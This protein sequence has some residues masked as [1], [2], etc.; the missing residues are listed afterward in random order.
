MNENKIFPEVGNDVNNEVTS[1]PSITPVEETVEVPTETVV[2]TP[3]VEVESSTEVVETPVVEPTLDFPVV[4]EVP[5]TPE[6]VETP[7]V[8][9]P[10]METPAVEETPIVEVEIPTLEVPAVETVEVPTEVVEETPVEVETPAVEPALDFPTVEEVPATPEVVEAPMETVEMTTPVEETPVVEQVMPVAENPEV[11]VPAENTTSAMPNGDTPKKNTLLPIIIV[12]IA[13]ALI[14][15]GAWFLF[16]RGAKAEKLS[17]QAFDK[18][19]GNVVEMTE[20]FDEMKIYEKVTEN[21]EVTV[22]FSSAYLASEDYE[23][24]EAV[25]EFL[26]S[27]L[28]KYSGAADVNTNN[29]HLDTILEF[30]KEEI[31]DLGFV[32]QDGKYYFHVLNKYVDVTDEIM[33]EMDGDTEQV[34]A[35]LEEIK[36]V[37]EWY[38]YDLI[39]K[40]FAKAIEGEE[41]DKENT[42]ITVDKK[43]VKVVKN[44]LRL[45]KGNTHRFANTFLDVIKSDA[46]FKK[47]AEILDLDMSELKF[48]K[49]DFEYMTP[50]SINFYSKGSDLVRVELYVEEEY[51]WDDEVFEYETIMS[52]T[53]GEKTDVIEMIEKENGDVYTN[54][55]IEFTVTDNS[56]K[57]EL[58]EDGVKLGAV[59][60]KVSGESL[61]LTLNTDIDGENLIASL[62]MNNKIEGNK[63][64]STIECSASVDTVEYFRVKFN[65][66]G[67]FEEK[68]NNLDLKDAIDYDDL[69]DSENEEITNYFD[70]IEDKFNDVFGVDDYYYDEDYYY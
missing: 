11:S 70:E 21:G 22:D 66:K 69:T 39:S 53:F 61:S 55:S 45:T 41:L 2:E 12:I 9:L 6:V 26:D 25:V 44:E 67:T 54:V 58:F 27:L 62:N 49:D 42:T 52:Y 34:N 20:L 5:T 47:I 59:E 40:A 28:L 7:M 30:D 63:F 24:Y 1:N 65:S 35:L 3:V 36:S 15:F 4:E 17:T 16:F 46:K 32:M 43:E 37:D 19:K 50:V 56:A 68:Y 60:L 57:I 13:V 14:G 29:V 64:N 10:A 23:S 8:E 33:G 31:F 38:F 51:E 18:F 48:S